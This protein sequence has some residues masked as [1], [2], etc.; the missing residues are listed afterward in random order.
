MPRSV[1][2][3]VLLLCSLFPAAILGQDAA[4][5]PSGAPTAV[6]PAPASTPPAPSAPAS[7]TLNETNPSAASGIHLDIVVTDRS[8]KPVPGLTASDFTLLDN[9]QP[10]KIV[11][12]HAYGASPDPSDP[13]VQVIVLFDTVNTDFDA[14]SYT[15]QQVENFLRRNGGHLAQPTSLA[16]L[17][18]TGVQPQGPPSLDGNALAAALDSSQSHLRTLTRSAGEYGAIE[19]MEISSQMLGG[20]VRE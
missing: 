6:Q 4:P 9:S 16:W 8:G 18:N 14:V 19:R 2:F 17:T 11:S 12:F 3:C 20:I 7:S 15:R 1:R 5:A 10:S 13:P